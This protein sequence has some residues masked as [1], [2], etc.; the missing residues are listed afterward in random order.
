MNVKLEGMEHLIKN[1][2]KLKPQIQIK[3]VETALKASGEVVRQ[4][5]YNKAPIK[6]GT[7]ADGFYV[8]GSKLAEG[9][10]QGAVRES[11][12]VG[13]PKIYDKNSQIRVGTNHMIAPDLERGTSREAAKPFMRRSA[14]DPLTKEAVIR[15]FKLAI[16]NTVREAVK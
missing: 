2:Q 1:L 6:G 4:D 10:R 11:I 12:K 14:D 8:S 5:A 7:S 16:E 13:D 15:E 9:G 3:A